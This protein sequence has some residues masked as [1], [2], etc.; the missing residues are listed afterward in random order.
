MIVP[1]DEKDI[2]CEYFNTAFSLVNDSTEACNRSEKSVLLSSSTVNS[3]GVQ[4]SSFLHYNLEFYK[5][6]GIS[7]Y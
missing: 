6:L 5:P 2:N 3:K 7:F 4:D 1:S